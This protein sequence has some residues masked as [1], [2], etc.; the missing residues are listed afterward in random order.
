M[1]EKAEAHMFRDR[2]GN[3]SPT[4]QR[5]GTEKYARYGLRKT[6]ELLPEESRLSNDAI[7]ELIDMN[8]QL[9]KT[10]RDRED[11][12]DRYGRLTESLQSKLIK[13]TNLNNKLEREKI[14]LELENEK[15]IDINERLTNDLRTTSV[16]GDLKYS[17]KT[18]KGDDENTDD[19]FIPKRGHTFKDTTESNNTD[20]RK[21]SAEVLNKKL[22]TLIEYLSEDKSGAKTGNS[23]QKERHDHWRLTDDDDDDIITRESL[24]IKNLEDQVEELRKKTLLKQE[25]ELRKISLSNEL[26]ELATKLSSDTTLGDDEVNGLKKHK[27][28][29]RDHIRCTGCHDDENEKT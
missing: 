18:R 19:I 15:L 1:E 29:N 5:Y 7:N 14:E 20:L 9:K 2:R 28:H 12:L 17:Q 21:G 4:P 16:A 10:L 13:Y 22:D 8:R 24:E 27:R 23:R 25:N 6:D 3:I 11:E 26:L